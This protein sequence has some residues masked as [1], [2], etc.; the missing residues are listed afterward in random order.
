MSKEIAC[1][2]K[3]CVSC[4]A[5]DALRFP[6]IGSAILL[7]LFLMFKLLPKELVNAVLTVYFVVLG[8]VAITA[9]IVPFVAPLFTREQQIRE[10]NLIKATVPFISKVHRPPPLPKQAASV[11]T[12]RRIAF[13]RACQSDVRRQCNR[14]VCHMGSHRSSGSH[15]AVQEPLEFAATVPELVCWMLSLLF[16][17]WYFLQKHWLANNALG[18]AFSIQGIEHLSLGAISTGLMP[19]RVNLHTFD[20]LPCQQCVRFIRLLHGNSGVS[21]SVIGLQ[22]SSCSQGCSSTTFFGS[23]ARR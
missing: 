9:S 2:D 1:L 18:L 21:H 14:S 20:A 12:H 23:S 17:C 10:Y 3:S 15:S 19:C 11:V 13:S 8:T 6:F 7:S 4:C 5:Q 22:E 16:C